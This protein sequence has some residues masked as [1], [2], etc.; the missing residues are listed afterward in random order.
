MRA[1]LTRQAA[2]EQAE[3]LAQLL[4][5][6][7][8]WQTTCREVVQDRDKVLKILAE[9]AEHRHEMFL[10]A[11]ESARFTLEECTLLKQARTEQ[12]NRVRELETE[13]DNQRHEM[14]Q[15]N[16]T[17]SRLRRECEAVQKAKL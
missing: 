16:E 4:E 13:R 12:D 7:Q 1:S 15:L 8:Q 11:E 3:M 2:A 6:K 17:V 5:E 9:Q 10:Q 14:R